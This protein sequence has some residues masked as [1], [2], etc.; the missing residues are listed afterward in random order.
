MSDGVNYY[1]RIYAKREFGYALVFEPP[2][3]L[4]YQYEYSIVK[5]ELFPDPSNICEVN[6]L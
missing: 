4:I 2:I 6:L 5:T 3:L 1:T